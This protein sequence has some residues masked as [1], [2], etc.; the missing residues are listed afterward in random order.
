MAQK[1]RKENLLSDR[2]PFDEV[3]ALFSKEF[4]YLEV[5]RPFMVIKIL[6]FL[7]STFILAKDINERLN[8]MP[9]WL[10]N[11]ILNVGVP[12]RKKKVYLS[13][14]KR[15]KKG[16]VKLRQK[17]AETFCTSPYHTNQIIDLL[18]LQ[19]E[20]PEEYFGLKKGE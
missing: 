16:D 19:D 5:I 15:T 20:K 10:V 18:R 9:N 4:G 17:V 7:P 14:P 12:K 13:F 3:K 11:P 1:K 6:S 8:G 2:N